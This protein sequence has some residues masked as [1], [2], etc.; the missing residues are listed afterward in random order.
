MPLLRH[1]FLFSITLF[2]GAALPAAD[3]FLPGVRRIVFLGDS[4]TYSGQYVDYFE[5]FL[6]TH[7]S[8]RRFEVINLGLPS[9]TVSGLSEKGHAGGK[10]P[11]PTLHERLDRVLAQTKPDL[12]FACYGMNDGIYKP[13]AEERFEKFRTGVLSLRQKVAAASA[14][15]IHLTPPTFDSEPIK[16]RTSPGD[17][18][19]ERPFVQYNE[20]L[21]RYS[22]W[23][24]TQRARGW[25]VIDVH[26]PM[27]RALAEKRAANPDFRFA[28]DGVHC[29]AAG[30][31]IFTREILRDL[32]QPIDNFTANARYTEL[33]AL[34]H[35]RGRLLT[36]AWLNVIGHE[37]PG[38]AKGL[39][40]PEAQIKAAELETKIRDLAT[41]LKP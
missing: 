39:P 34:V 32:D 11:R 10:F 20:V 4:I 21:D 16:N 7:F 2:S 41:A 38:M 27:N 31:W 17:A 15:I 28:A 35:Q 23:L 22:E 3:D 18:E 33:L 5:A 36:D 40:L 37:R 12:V 6:F 14:Q 29:D 25:H 26:G 24:L 9:E 30:H 1:L 19:D 8:E 13:F